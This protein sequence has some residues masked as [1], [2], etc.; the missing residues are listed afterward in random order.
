MSSASTNDKIVCRT[1]T[2]GKQPTRIDRWKFDTIRKAILKVV[3][4]KGEG[5]AFRDLTGL[6]KKQISSADQ[7]KIGSLMWYTTTVKL[8]L[9]V[10]G[11]LERVEG[12]GPQRLLRA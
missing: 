10:R 5:I 1:P 11:E 3:P 12:S 2:P 6:V 7:K 8:E 9:E 4:R